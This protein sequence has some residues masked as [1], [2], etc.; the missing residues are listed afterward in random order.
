[1]TNTFALPRKLITFAII[2]PLAALLGYL[3]AT[4][5]S[6]DTLSALGVVLMV[7]SMPL[8]LRYHHP[9]LILSWNLAL[10]ISFLP[11]SP[12]LWMPMAMMSFTLSLLAYLLDKERK[13]IQVPS[14]TWALIFLA[15]VVLFTAK[16][17][18]GIGL[19]SLGG[20]VYGGR[21][22][23]Y[24]FFAIVGY[25][26]LSFQPIPLKRAGVYSGMF[27]LSGISPVVSNLLYFVPSLWFLYTFIPVDFALN[28]VVEDFES[29]V[30]G[31]GIVRTS[32][33]AFGAEAV[34]SFM[35]VRYGVRG[36][37][38]LTKPWRLVIWAA[39]MVIGLLGGFRSILLS[40]ILLIGFQLYFE[41]LMR[42]RIFVPL[43]L[44]G[45]VFFALLL[46]L[47]QRLPLPLQRTLSILPFVDVDP[48][49][50]MDAN[51]STEWRLQMWGLLTPEIPKYL[52]VGKGYSASATDHYLAQE[53]AKR[54]IGQH[55]ESYIVAGDFHNG[56]LSVILPF[57]IGGVLAF[58]A[59][60]AASIRVLYR[61]QKYGHPQLRKVNT[62]LLS[63]FLARAIFFL[64]V[65]GAIHSDMPLFAGLV[66]LSVSLNRGMAREE[67]QIEPAAA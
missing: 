63:Y 61:N 22:Y 13:L 28:Q 62:F 3:L 67:D 48:V 58:T 57:G 60:L 56:P 29:R 55:A 46:P 11:G 9:M 15:V 40:Y 65:F 16:V 39:F 36:L 51:A 31:T 4:P 50:R 59:F 41:G 20:S 52:W 25:F 64:G 42:S 8:L 6:F 38:D 2:L 30:M 27:L 66:G 43:V 37:L 10:C 24:I 26:A 34:T 47:A 53:S 1:M 23:V 19:R 54:G 14:V 21:K 32:G 45:I 49:V 18:G 33:I 5:D 7:L 35:L 44:A 17:T 12:N